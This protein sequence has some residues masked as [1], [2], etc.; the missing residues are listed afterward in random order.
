MLGREA[1][2]ETRSE[3]N[4]GGKEKHVRLLKNKPEPRLP[5]L[6]SLLLFGFLR[7]V[8]WHARAYSG[9]ELKPL[10]STEGTKPNTFS[11]AWLRRNT[12]AGYV[13]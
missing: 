2:N 12:S 1:Y 5:R 6:A 10:E 3:D 13:H 7:L 4:E 8:P 9:R 11:S